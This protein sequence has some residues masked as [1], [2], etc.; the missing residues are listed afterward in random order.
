MDEVITP[1]RRKSSDVTTTPQTE[2]AR[3]IALLAQVAKT[4]TA[5]VP[6][7]DSLRR[8]LREPAVK[9]P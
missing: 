4:E 5:L 3:R 1:H 6:M 8:W 2:R 9:A 7:N